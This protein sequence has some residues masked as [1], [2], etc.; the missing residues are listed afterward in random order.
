[1]ECQLGTEGT[2]FAAICLNCKD[3]ACAKSQEQEIKSQKQY[4]GL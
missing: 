3:E 4:H 1:M 2:V